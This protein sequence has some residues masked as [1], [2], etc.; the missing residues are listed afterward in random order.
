MENSNYNGTFIKWRGSSWINIYFVSGI[1]FCLLTIFSNI[2][3]IDHVENNIYYPEDPS[4]ERLWFEFCYRIGF[5]IFGCGSNKEPYIALIFNFLILTFLIFT[6]VKYLK[7]QPSAPIIN[8]FLLLFICFCRSL[9][10]IID[11]GYVI[12][13]FIAFLFYFLIWV[14]P[15][16]IYFNK[17]QVLVKK[18]KTEN[19][20]E[21][22]YGKYEIVNCLDYKVD[23]YVLFECFIH[24]STIN[25][26]TKNIIKPFNGIEEDETQTVTIEKEDLL[27]FD[28]N[29]DE[30]EKISANIIAISYGTQ[31]YEECD[32]LRH[33][34]KL[35]RKEKFKTNLS[36]LKTVILEQK[37]NIPPL[38]APV[39]Q[40]NNIDEDVAPVNTVN[41]QN[42]NNA[43]QPHNY[44]RMEN[45]KS[46]KFIE[47]FEKAKK[48]LILMISVFI[49]VLAIK[50]FIAYLLI[51]GLILFSENIL[52]ILK[53]DNIKTMSSLLAII[54]S[55]LLLIP[56]IDNSDILLIVISLILIGLYISEILI[57]Q[58]ENIYKYPK[59][60]AGVIIIISVSVSLFVFLLYGN[61]IKWKKDF[62]AEFLYNI[63]DL[64]YGC[65]ITNISDDCLEDI[66]VYFKCQ[67]SD[68]NTKVLKREITSLKPDESF[69]VSYSHTY[70]IKIKKITYK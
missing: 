64:S 31:G 6:F 37:P 5:N 38:E 1:I 66:T 23:G 40:E 49:L 32:A 60:F 55:F 61:T 65:K 59:L 46:G 24:Y 7:A 50:D 33:Q 54:P 34:R 15:N 30:V 12:L 52:S 22:I 35:E 4:A 20:S 11:T 25:Y 63:R 45:K 18:I 58:S 41:L 28:I 29:L 68:G 70:K 57:R 39:Q 27:K 62:H 9:M 42:D 67:D 51:I 69:S 8:T 44:V 56:A 53:I 2:G 17:R 16:L 47:I 14:L 26:I 19:Q 21:N 36:N 3:N 43:I 10:F 13:F 48:L